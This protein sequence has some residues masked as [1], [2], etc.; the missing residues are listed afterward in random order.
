M[1]YIRDSRAVMG[2]KDLKSLTNS[3]AYCKAESGWH[4]EDEILDDGWVQ[5][6]RKKEPA[7]SHLDG[8]NWEVLVVN[9]SNVNAFWLPDGPCKQQ[10][11]VLVVKHILMG[12]LRLL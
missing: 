12:L 2:S 10:L 1:G 6:S 4:K 5:K 8:L 7:T 3:S 9:E 11:G